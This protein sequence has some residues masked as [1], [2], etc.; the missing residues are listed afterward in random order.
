LP[1]KDEGKPQ[2]HQAHECDEAGGGELA[3][4]GA[5]FDEACVTAAQRKYQKE[6]AQAKQRPDQKSDLKGALRHVALKHAVFRPALVVINGDRLS[7]R[8]DTQLFGNLEVSGIVGDADS[9]TFHATA[10]DIEGVSHRRE[11][12]Y[13]PALGRGAG[14]T[15]APRDR[16]RLRSGRD[17]L[18]CCRQPTPR[19]PDFQIFAGDGRHDEAVEGG[20]HAAKKPFECHGSPR[21]GR[22]VRIEPFHVRL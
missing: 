3:R 14:L 7:D 21:L 15:G 9:R 17:D 22:Q 11:V 1:V 20:Q 2:R 18:A 4:I 12:S 6:A 5:E 16:A 8:I 13:F 10:V 19:A